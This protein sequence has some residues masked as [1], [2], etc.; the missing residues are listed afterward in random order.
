VLEGATLA[1]GE[2]AMRPGEVFALH[3]RDLHL[4]K[5]LVH[6]RRQIDLDTGQITWPKDDDGSWVVMSPAFR[7]HVERM[8]RMGKVLDEQYGKIVF[9]APRGG[10]MRRAIWSGLWNVVRVGAGMPGQEF[11]ELKHRAIQWMVDPVEGGGLGLDPAT[12]AEMVGHDDGGYLIATVYTRLGQ[13][14]A[15]ARAQRAMDAFQHRRD[16]VDTR[17]AAPVGRK[18]GRLVRPRPLRSASRGA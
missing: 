8:P 11:Y 2:A 3:R 10:Y 9:P 12:A 16:G 1:V 15:I 6:V 13:R 7:E 14:R 18:R 4:D 5:G 17:A